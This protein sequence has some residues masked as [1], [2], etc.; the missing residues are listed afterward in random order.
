MNVRISILSHNLT[1]FLDLKYT[2]S[3][4]E[5]NEMCLYNFVSWVNLTEEKD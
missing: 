2:N 3:V 1:V 4:G 5:E